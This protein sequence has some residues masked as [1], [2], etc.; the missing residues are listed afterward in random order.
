MPEMKSLP[1]PTAGSVTEEAKKF[2]EEEEL[3][4]RTV[5]LLFTQFPRNIDAAHVYAKVVVVDRLYN[6][7][8]RGKDLLPLARHIAG[9]RLDT[10][11]AEGSLSAVDRIMN[12]AGVLKYYSFASKFCSWHKPA[13]YPIYDRYVDEALWFYRKRDSFEKFHRQDLGYYDRFV[14]VIQALQIFYG[15]AGLTFKEFD[16]FLWHHQGGTLLDAWPEADLSIA[17]AIGS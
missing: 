12:G 11:L 3:V 17:H 8:I 15:L 10:L 7:Q 9:L 6:T 1:S 5:S 14:T 2:D 13:I 4:E 16:K